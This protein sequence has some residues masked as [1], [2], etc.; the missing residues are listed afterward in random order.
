MPL[1][2]IVLVSGGIDST[3]A[4]WWAKRKGWALVP[5][6]INYHGRPKA[7][8]RALRNILKEAGIEGLIR[9]PM[10]F[11][12]E[13]ENLIKEGVAGENLASAPE[14]YIP[15]RNMIFYSIAAYYAEMIDADVI[16]GGHN[17]G[18]PEEFPDSGKGFFSSMKRVFDIGLLNS[19]KRRIRIV[20]PLAGKTKAGVLGLGLSLN[21]PLSSTWSCNTDGA[22]PCG[23][24]GSCLERSEAYAE[25]QLE[26]L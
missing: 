9:V 4:L 23:K 21:A 8:R 25:L 26:E 6:T 22:R 17:A 1:K 11:L 14:G 16:V 15:A 19:R 18:D 20:L 2:A 13:A 12:K 10:N 24:C 5:M 3:V 7:E